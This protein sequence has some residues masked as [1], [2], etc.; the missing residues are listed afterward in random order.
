MSEKGNTVIREDVQKEKYSMKE[1]KRMKESRS[2][3][4]TILMKL[5][6]VNHRATLKLERQQFEEAAENLSLILHL[7]PGHRTHIMKLT[8][9][10][11]N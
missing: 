4:R 1:G 2:Q 8:E 10:A 7:P 6:F 5:H 3:H 9:E 11:E